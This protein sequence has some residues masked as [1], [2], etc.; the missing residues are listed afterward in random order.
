MNFTPSTPLVFLQVVDTLAKAF[1]Q[2]TNTTTETALDVTFFP[3]AAFRVRPVT[4]CTASLEGHT[5]AVL[6]VSFDPK[7]LS[8]ASGSGDCTV[9][10]IEGQ[11]ERD[12][13]VVYTI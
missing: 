11:I 10:G 6:C 12:R 9:R 2:L 5:E 13:S 1:A 3:L 4:R 7:G 8:L